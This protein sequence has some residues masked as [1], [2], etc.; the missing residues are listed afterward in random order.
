MT[1]REEITDEWPKQAETVGHT[2][3]QLTYLP[4]TKSDDSEEGQQ[5]RD[6][7]Q[8]SHVLHTKGLADAERYGNTESQ[9]VDNDGNWL[10]EERAATPRKEQDSMLN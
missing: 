4:K 6:K 8:K 5:G 7:A 3:L 10:E 2:S 1:K 9:K